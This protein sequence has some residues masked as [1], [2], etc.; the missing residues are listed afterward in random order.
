M[1]NGLAN[2][3]FDDSSK[4]KSYT[5]TM[6]CDPEES[7]IDKIFIE[8]KRWMLDNNIQGRPKRMI[9]N[10]NSQQSNSGKATSNRNQHL[11]ASQADDDKLRKNT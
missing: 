3:Y 10:A 6:I 11:L 7:G 1:A 4:E 5:L 2:E 9:I 8:Y